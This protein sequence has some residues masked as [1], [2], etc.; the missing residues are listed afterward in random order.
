M[1]DRDRLVM[2]KFDEPVFHFRDIVFQRLEIFHHPLDHKGE[3]AGRELIKVP[4][5]NKSNP[6]FTVKAEGRL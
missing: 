6:A 1:V 5:F 4:L 2:K 3:T